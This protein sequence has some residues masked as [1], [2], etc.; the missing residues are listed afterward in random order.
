MDDLCVSVAVIT[1]GQEKYIEQA[2]NS[3]LMQNVNFNYEIV[4][5]EDNSPDNTRK[6]LKEFELKYPDKI[7]LILRD[8]NIGP[9]KN[10]YDV[11]INCKGKY[12]TIL[13]GDDYWT[14]KNKLQI[15]YDF[16]EQNNEYN[17]VSHIIDIVDEN[18]IFIES[19][20]KEKYCGKNFSMKSFLKKPLAPFVMSIMFKNIFYNSEDKYKIL[21]EA[22]HWIGDNT[23][24]AILLDISDIFILDYHMSAYRRITKKEATNFS[25]LKIF[26]KGVML[27]NLAEKLN[28]FFQ[29]KYNFKYLKVK[30]LSDIVLW[31][32][33]EGKKSEVKKYMNSMDFKL[34][35]L[36]F[37]Q[38][39]N[40][41]FQR[42]FLLLK[43]V[44]AK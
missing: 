14:D 15:Q 6:I 20:P 11:L 30:Y 1:Y 3:I 35:C 13:E 25:S 40:F 9:T 34:K 27:Y 7:R 29:D 38:M 43:T 36:V 4:I 16:L 8:E 37:F 17:S 44:I 32:L 21:H 12:I 10:T 5:G 31:G 23:L 24:Q 26:D 42:V 2:L 33:I 39:I 18:G 28:V 19:R 22:S 41:T